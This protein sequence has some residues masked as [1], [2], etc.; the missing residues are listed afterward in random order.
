MQNHMQ[1][2]TRKCPGET[3]GLLLPV[4]VPFLSVVEHLSIL[5]GFFYCIEHS[6]IFSRFVVVVDSF[7]F[8]DNLPIDYCW[9]QHFFA[10]VFIIEAEAQFRADGTIVI[11]NNFF[12]LIPHATLLF[13]T[14]EK[15][16]S[17]SEGLPI[18]KIDGKM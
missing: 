1:I 4:V 14:R 6:E 7:I 18:V 8:A 15:L 10:C 5:F 2:S 17:L 13:V 3:R 16:L 11:V 12:I 9:D